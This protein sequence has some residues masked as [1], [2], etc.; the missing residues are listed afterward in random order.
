MREELQRSREEFPLPDS[1]DSLGPERVADELTRLTAIHAPRKSSHSTTDPREGATAPDSTP[2]LVD[3]HRG[4]ATAPESM[5]ENKGPYGICTSEIEK[6]PGSTC[7][8]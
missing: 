3:E 6:T 7:V 4:G 5:W 1:E 8:P 2:P